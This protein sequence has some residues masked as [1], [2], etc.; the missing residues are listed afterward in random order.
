MMG[1]RAGFL[2]LACLLALLGT[3]PAFGQAPE[4]RRIPAAA[5]AT[6]LGR[7]VLDHGG[8]EIGRLVDVVTDGSGRPVAAVLD[9]GGYMGVGSR[10]IA[11]DWGLLR[12]TIAGDDT[13]VIVDLDGDIIAAAPEYKGGASDIPVLT[14]PAPKQ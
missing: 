1:R 7:R 11:V 14:G 12:L 5:A 6:L 10:K 4:L 13:R 8:Q 2:E 3:A 9:V